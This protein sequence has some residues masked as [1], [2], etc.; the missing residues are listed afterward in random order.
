MK[1]AFFDRDGT[2]IRDYPD[3]EWK[4]KAEPEFFD[5]SLSALKKMRSIGYEIIIVTNQHIINGG[6]ISIEEYHRFTERLTSILSDNGVDV[7]DIFFCPHTREENCNC[8]KPKP[9]MIEEALRMYPSID[10][11]QSF[12][13][14]DSVSDMELAARFGLKFWGL[15]M[16][17][18]MCAN[19]ISSLGKILPF[20][21]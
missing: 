6:I 18:S 14:G 10:L 2:L 9:G 5:D 20:L 11:S 13:A 15:G 1:A 12:M 3:E 17:A 7:L 16:D 19:P 8:R 4:H 21:D